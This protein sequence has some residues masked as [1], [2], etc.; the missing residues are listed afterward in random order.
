MSQEIDTIQGSAEWWKLR[1]GIPTG[2]QFS[3]IIT[4]KKGDYAAGA[5]HYA[6]ELI[7]EALG[8]QS[9]FTG[10]PDTARGN[11]L[12]AEAQMARYAPRN[13]SAGVRFFY[14]RLRAI[15]GES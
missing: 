5:K 11:M 12:E 15:R 3:R 4:A 13:Q 2:S 14:Q 1:K 8:W 7:A 10:T 6:A 9:G